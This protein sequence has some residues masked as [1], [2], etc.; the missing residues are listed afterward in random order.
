MIKYV[1]IREKFDTHSEDVFCLFDNV[2]Q[3]R[4]LE[5]KASRE[6]AHFLG[7]DKKGINPYLAVEFVPLTAKQ[8]KKMIKD[9]IKNHFEQ[10]TMFD[11][12]QGQE[13]TSVKDWYIET[14]PTDELGEG[15]NADVTF[16]NVF[17]ALDAYQDIYIVLGGNADS[18]IRERVFTR[19]AQI[20]HVDYDY[21]YEQWLKCA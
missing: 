15:L 21:I 1:L 12:R 16:E 4:R 17:E 6:V 3:Q 18:V 20:M 11:Y 9:Y 19:L 7:C 2:R 14:F 13:K 8:A 10:P 5:L